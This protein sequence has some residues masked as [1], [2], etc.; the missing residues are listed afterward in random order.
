MLEEAVI[1]FLELYRINII[2]PN[3]H[4]YVRSVDI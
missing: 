2:S 4:F 3:N 1:A